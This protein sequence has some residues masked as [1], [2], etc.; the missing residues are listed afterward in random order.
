MNFVEGDAN[1]QWLQ[2]V[3]GT[4]EEVE[5]LFW[6]CEW[7][8]CFRCGLT[9]DMR[10]GRKWAKPACGRPLDGRV[11]PQFAFRGVALETAFL[12]GDFAAFFGRVSV[13]SRAC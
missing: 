7:H 1:G 11:R 10:G 3:V 8:W 13:K 9:F 6:R 12:T 5:D 4:L 2:A